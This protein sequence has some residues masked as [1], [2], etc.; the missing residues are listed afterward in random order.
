MSAVDRLAR[1]QALGRPAL[2]T[3]EA[4][5]A[6]G[7]TLPA[8]SKMLS[9]LGAA[10]LV[11]KVRSGIWHLGPDTPDPATVLPLLTAPYPSY[12]SGWSALARHQMI[13]QIPREV[14]AVSLDRPKVVETTSGR[15]DI[16]HIHPRLFGGFG[17]ATGTRAGVAT[18]AKA[19]FDVVYL[20]SARQ[21]DVTLPELELPESFDHGELQA[22]VTKVP[23]AR[24]QTLTATN[25]DRIV[26]GAA[27]H[28]A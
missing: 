1:L 11:T 19:L 25:L 21:G 7:S 14:F 5:V 17:D 3:G 28:Y 4:A 26:A 10:G 8:A 12:I 13:E 23:T 20:F 22:W 9:R 27:R 15:Y 6:W 24:L 18:P 2:S 16:H